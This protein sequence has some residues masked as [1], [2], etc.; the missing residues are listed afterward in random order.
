MTTDDYQFT[1]VP[2]NRDKPK[3]SGKTPEARVT[4]ACDAYLQM[5]GCL[6]IRTNSGQ[7]KDD[8]GNIIMGAKGGTSDKTLLLPGG[9]FCA[10]ELKAGKNTLSDAQKRYKQRVEALGGLFIEAHSKD[11]LRAALVA[12]Y[13]LQCVEDWETLGRA[14]KRR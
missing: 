2:L 8:A 14:R 4:A 7:W 9:R 3:R 13:G 11:D 1:H 5:I 12:A 6:A 10:L